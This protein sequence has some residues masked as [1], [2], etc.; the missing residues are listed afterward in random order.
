MLIINVTCHFD[1]DDN[2]FNNATVAK[3]KKY[4]PL[5]AFLESKGKSCEIY[6]FVVDALGS[7]YIRNEILLN[8]LGMTRGYKSLF[9]KL[10]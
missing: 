3:V 1:N 2:A 10:C 8:E 9:R 7:W 4:Q 5:K 6:S